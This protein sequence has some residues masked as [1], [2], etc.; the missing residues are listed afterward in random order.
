MGKAYVA[1]RDGRLCAEGNTGVALIVLAEL[2]EAKTK[3]LD[4]M[5]RLA[6]LVAA[7]NI[8]EV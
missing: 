8:L 1:D 7:L 6:K 5:T 2:R 4:G 3:V